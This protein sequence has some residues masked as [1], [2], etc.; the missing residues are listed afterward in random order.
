[1]VFGAR[2]ALSTLG[3]HRSQLAVDSGIASYKGSPLSGV[4]LGSTSIRGAFESRG[5]NGDSPNRLLLG[6]VATS[7]SP[8]CTSPCGVAG[9]CSGCVVESS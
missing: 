7:P 4:S 3:V 1:M 2:E 9:E 8:Q 5:R 6:D